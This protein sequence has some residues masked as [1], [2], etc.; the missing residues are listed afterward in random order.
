MGEVEDQLDSF[1]KKVLEKLSTQQLD[2]SRSAESENVS[3]AEGLALV[4]L[5][6]R[7]EANMDEVQCP[8]RESPKR[9]SQDFRRIG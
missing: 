9:K 2:S 8:K 4:P 3:E 7:A 6:N 5:E 1:R